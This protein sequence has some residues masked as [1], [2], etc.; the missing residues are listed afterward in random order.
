M[1][2]KSERSP[3]L[4]GWWHWV[5]DSEMPG[6]GYWRWIDSPSGRQ[7]HEIQGSEGAD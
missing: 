7:I 2:N 6:M 4:G 1:K 3:V 5:C